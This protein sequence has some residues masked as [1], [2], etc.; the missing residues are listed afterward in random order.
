[1]KE[2]DCGHYFLSSTA[3]DIWKRGDDIGSGR[4]L[5]CL[6]AIHKESYFR[7]VVYKSR[8][9]DGMVL[10]ELA[11]TV[12][13]QT[14]EV[15]NKRG[16]EGRLK[17]DG[18]EYTAYF[19]TAFKGNYLK[20]LEKELRRVTA[21]KEFGSWQPADG[22]AEGAGRAG[23]EGGDVLSARTQK[24]LN[25]LSPDCRQLL[26]WKHI[27][28]L[29]HDEIARRKNINRSSSIKMLSRCGRR[30]SEIWRHMGH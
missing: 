11:E 13:L 12:F 4:M 23:G 17:L 26:V 2:Q 5:A 15:F 18:P 10:L 29:S 6:S 22:E 1:M 27:G 16:R 19:F 30:F 7:R 14:W 8:L 25:K 3:A 20:S 9:I 24:A 21:E 28:G